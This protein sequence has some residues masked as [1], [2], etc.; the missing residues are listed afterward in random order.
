[1]LLFQISC[2]HCC[3]SSISHRAFANVLG[4]FILNLKGLNCLSSP[5]R[6]IYAK[7]IF[8]LRWHRV[9]LNLLVSYLVQ[10]DYLHSAKTDIGFFFFDQSYRIKRITKDMNLLFLTLAG[11]KKQFTEGA[12]FS[13]VLL[14]TPV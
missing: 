14:L 8:I 7:Y 4:N 12:I 5:G 3:H 9:L 6:F 13:H 2:T 10:P 11:V 1:M